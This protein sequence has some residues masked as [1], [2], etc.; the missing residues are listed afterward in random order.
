MLVHLWHVRYSCAGLSSQQQ[1]Q[2]PAGL[3]PWVAMQQKRDA[4]MDAVLCGTGPSE[5]ASSPSM[6]CCPDSGG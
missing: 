3:L 6:H 5:A 4:C 1:Q 2:Q